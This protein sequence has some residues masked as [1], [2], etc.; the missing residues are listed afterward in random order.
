MTDQGPLITF[1]P[2][3]PS[4]VI[5]FDV[6]L[7]SFYE[8]THVLDLK[9]QKE[10]WIDWV[11]STITEESEQ[12]QGTT[13]SNTGMTS[14]VQ[15]S[16]FL[17][18]IW[19]GLNSLFGGINSFP[20]QAEP[21][22]RARN[23]SDQERIISEIGPE[24]KVIIPKQFYK[25]FE[26]VP[27]TKGLKI[28]K[29]EQ[30]RNI[31]KISNGLCIEAQRTMTG[32]YMLHAVQVSPLIMRPKI[33]IVEKYRLENYLGNYGMGKTISS[34]YI[35]PKSKLTLTIKSW[36]TVTDTYEEASS[37]FDSLTTSASSSFENTL[38]TER[39]KSS[40]DKE[41]R[42][43][44]AEVKASASFFGVG[45]VEAKA[46]TKGSSSSARTEF[47]KD[48]SNT[49]NSHASE[50]SSKREMQHNVTA[51]VQKEEGEE[52]TI[53]REIENLNAGHVLN[54]VIRELNQEYHSTLV[55]KD[56]RLVFTLGPR[57]FVDEVPLYRI[58]EFL[59]KYLKN[60]DQLIK[61]YRDYILKEIAYIKNYQG[62]RLSIIDILKFADDQPVNNNIETA[63]SNFDPHQHYILIKK[64]KNGIGKKVGGRTEGEEIKVEGIPV[65]VNTVTLKTDGVICSSLLDPGLGL[66]DYSIKMQ[67]EAYRK[68]KI[69]NDFN[70]AN[71]EKHNLARQLIANGP[72]EA[73]ERYVK[74]YGPVVKPEE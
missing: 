53:V 56:I 19:N 61:E 65:E 33:A 7:P 16:S 35:H 38:N 20:K 45:S 13:G 71:I 67:V 69:Q 22:L 54:F 26:D 55:L 63:I 59:R 30:I 62:R 47:G 4:A 12:A 73:V 37:I 46:G 21:M 14:A 1:D 50:S 9:I 36:T 44:Y 48:V 24:S 42:E 64:E 74:I 51:K 15:A 39:S 52:E 57:L 43:S 11:R 27:E 70:E 34:F 58:D 32:H 29:A 68:E 60:D 3:E 17:S 28:V 66:D 10:D 5:R 25:Y 23:L 2:E 72:N 41:A 8:G 40:E 31:E 6:P 49:V 18:N